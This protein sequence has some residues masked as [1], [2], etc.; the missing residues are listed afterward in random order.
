MSGALPSPRRVAGA[1]DVLLALPPAALRVL[2][3]RLIDRLDVLDGD[4]EA[5]PDDDGE[6]DHDGEAPP[7]EPGDCWTPVKGPAE[8]GAVRLLG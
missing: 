6:A 2:A 5:E 7:W 4:P 1:L 8:C 3:D